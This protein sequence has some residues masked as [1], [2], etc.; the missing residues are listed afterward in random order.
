M[1]FTSHTAHEAEIF[2]PGSFV[3]FQGVPGDGLS[4]TIDTMPTLRDED[5]EVIR[6]YQQDDS[7]S[8]Y[9]HVEG[10]QL[11]DDESTI[12]SALTGEPGAHAANFLRQAAGVGS[13]GGLLSSPLHPP[14]RA[15][16]QPVSLRA[17][18]PVPET[19]HDD[20][21][22]LLSDSQPERDNTATSA[23]VGDIINRFM[24]QHSPLPVN[25]NV[26]VNRAEER[27]IN[28]WQIDCRNREVRQRKEWKQTF[29]AG[30]EDDDDD[31]LMWWQK[32]GRLA[33]LESAPTKQSGHVVRNVIGTLA[34][35]STV[36]A[37]EL[38]HLDSETFKLIPVTLSGG[39]SATVYPRGRPGRIQLLRLES[40]K[41]G[42]VVLSLNGY[43]FL[44]PGLPSIY[45]DP[46]VWPW[47]VSC[48][49]GAY[50]REGLDLSSKH[51]DTLPYGTI[52]RVARKTVNSMGLSRLRVQAVVETS[53]GTQSVVEGW[54]SEFLNPLSGQ[55]GLI[56]S[57]LPFPVPA[58]YRVALR[59]GAVIRSDVELSSPQTDLA[60]HG[61]ILTIVRRAFSEHPMDQ[62]IERLQLAGGG[63]W[64]SVR[65]NRPPPSNEL[66]VEFIGIDGT[67]DPESPGTYHLEAQRRNRQDR[68]G[69]GRASRSGGGGAGSEDL[70]NQGELSSIDDDEE[71][72]SPDSSIGSSGPR[73][74]FKSEK[75]RPYMGNSPTRR[76]L[77][78]EL[79]LIC[80]AEER[81]ATI[82]HGETGH[83]ACCLQC[84]RILK[85]RGDS[86]SIN[87]SF[88]LFHPCHLNLLSFLYSV[89]YVA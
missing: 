33:L 30:T 82:V 65:L 53:Q 76:V 37:T 6:V 59:E 13:F 61:A 19:A 55:R 9:H 12:T 50:V 4:N 75:K 48:L 10:N 77:G 80:L 26:V 78:K 67:F 35:G 22:L 51:V 47:R 17:H 34:P 81:T 3:V 45:V 83:V 84:A 40:P 39:H 36:V 69:S 29:D 79:C 73:S 1:D 85:A 89:L 31:L 23:A 5:A 11:F 66:V 58:L 74:G 54:C 87:G 15:T 72:R 32:E 62:C 27:A 24:P 43:A 64:I 14:I 68:E 86:V 7:T 63:G 41:E 52:V 42:Y 2:L 71:R 38:I 18:L 21:F 25:P 16:A 56:A 60:P 8:E 28:R 49:E 88:R 57:P 46:Q 70:R 44:G 20:S